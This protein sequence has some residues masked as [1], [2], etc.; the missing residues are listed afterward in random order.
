MLALPVS[1]LS[2]T[3]FSCLVKPTVRIAFKHTMAA[4]TSKRV[5]RICVIGGGI[6][7][8][9]T[10]FRL[11]NEVPNVEVT[12]V[13]KD[14]SPNTTG[15]GSA[16]YWRP[17]FVTGTPDEKI[18][19]WGKETFDHLR[20]ISLTQEGG[21]L[22]VFTAT[23]CEIYRSPDEKEAF[24][25]DIVLGYRRMSEDE[26]KQYSGDYGC[27][28]AFTTMMC[29]CKSYLPWLRERFVAN[30]GIVIQ[31]EVKNLSEVA[32]GYDVIVNC[33]GV[34]AKYLVNDQEVDPLKGQIIRVEAPWV[35]HFV[36][37]E[38]DDLYILL[39][40]S[41]LALGGTHEKGDWTTTID[42]VQRKRIWE[43]C[44]RLMPSL[45]KAKV[46]EEWAG[47]RPGRTSI[48]LEKELVQFDNRVVPVVHNYGHGGSGV[49]LHWG[50]AG[51]AVELVKESL[52]SKQ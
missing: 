27:G 30:G 16:G 13:S 9:S 44:C 42:P 10:A 3:C 29:E 7:G 14:F 40:S 6:I 47:F 18:I 22:G 15:D 34:Y 49:T 8:L 5:S 1:H 12:V 35:K 4:A 19:K 36:S 26:L 25:K 33:P 17:F 51:E 11:L 32:D 37:A 28:Y 43:G 41:T 38:D 46:V 2:R 45:E 50:S 20:K 52:L 31:R 21:A 23:G 24:W 48:R 39:G